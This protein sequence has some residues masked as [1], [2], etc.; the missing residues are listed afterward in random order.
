MAETP[1]DPVRPLSVETRYGWVI[2]AASLVYIMVAF[3]PSYLLVVSLKPIAA[4]FAWPRWVPSLAYSLLLLGT[5]LGGI[6][7]GL[8]ADRAGLGRPTLL[9]AVVAGSGIMAAS[10]AS[11]EWMLLFLCGPVIGFLGTSA[12]FSPLLTNTTRWFDRRRG[13]AVSIVA[14]GQAVAGAFWP[15]IFNYGVET[16]G[17][18]ETWFAYGVF[19]ICTMLPLV[20]IL[21]RPPPEPLTP[22]AAAPAA[23]GRRD[24]ALQQMPLAILSLAIV[25]CCVA[26]AM[27]LVHIVAYCTDLGFEAARGAE[28][29]SLLLACSAISRLGFGFL[30][31]RIGGLKTIFIG[32]GLQAIALSLFAMVDSLSG[33]FIV[34]ALFGLVFGGIVPAY[35]LATRELHPGSELG[36]RMGV[37]F[38]F[39]TAGMALG[40]F[41][42][43][44]IYDL[45][46]YYPL[47]FV[48]G[49]SF[50]IVNL[51]CLTW[52]IRYRATAILPQMSVA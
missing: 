22:P 36:W 49:V 50:N 9:G 25:G 46:A 21:R 19:A 4:G 41:L 51:L 24:A 34:S 23:S 35:A 6:V 29:L 47:A 48:V 31:D 38:F 52:L 27:P 13:I 12:A 40:G 1:E 45:T 11:D 43:G 39:G 14:S 2:V 44:W 10:F 18:R 8:W 16:V 32:A 30:S 15:Q 5:G 26:M 17:W 20:L 3:G 33:L 28:M 7:M 42:G 37:V